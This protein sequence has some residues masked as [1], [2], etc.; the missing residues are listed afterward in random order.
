MKLWVS[1]RLQ[2]LSDAEED[3][4]RLQQ[5]ETS[6]RQSKEKLPD[7]ANER[8]VFWAISTHCD[9]G[10][11]IKAFAIADWFPLCVISLTAVD[12]TGW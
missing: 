10:K 1:N 6:N 4:G 3:S 7:S 9:L 2:A 5:L 11:Q 8:K 12:C